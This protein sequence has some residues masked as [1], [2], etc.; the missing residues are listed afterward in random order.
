VRSLVAGIRCR[1]AGDEGE[2]DRGK[3]EGEPA[4]PQLLTGDGARG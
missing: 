2:R 4:Q 1:P 3:Q